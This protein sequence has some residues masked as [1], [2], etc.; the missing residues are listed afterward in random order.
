MVDVNKPVT[1][2][3]FVDAMNRF[4]QNRSAENEL[5]FIEKLGQ[6]H[7]LSPIILDGEIENGVLKEGTLINFKLLTNQDDESFFIAFTDWDEL[8]KWSKDHV[9]TLIMR[10]E[11]YKAM[12][13]KDPDVAKGFVIN[14]Y[15]QN[16]IITPQLMEY[17]ERRKSE[18]VITK[19]TKIMLGQPSN[20]P[21]EMV[22]ALSKFFKKHREVDEAYIFLA[23]REDED[24]P[25][26]LLVI[27]FEGD[28]SV[29]F[30]QVAAIAQEY[31]GK[32]E[33]ID[34]VPLDSTFGREAVK[35]A[36][37]FYKKKRWALF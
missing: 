32:D 11:D 31:L 8:R 24:K 29:L 4:L 15:N 3:E 12:L 23:Q 21:H 13:L 9:Q 35:G 27:G 7:F 10:Y 16:I 33:Y 37:P 2:P 34:I 5:A 19:D 1:N 6:A 14:P 20:Y 25:N 22:N 28:K 36:E 18:V 17:I 30:P 26:L